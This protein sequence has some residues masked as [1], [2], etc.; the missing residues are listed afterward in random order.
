[1]AV[2]ML[3]NRAVATIRRLQKANWTAARAIADPTISLTLTRQGTGVIAAQD[4]VAIWAKAGSRGA[5]VSAPRSA[6]ETPSIDVTF[7]RVVE[8]GFDVEP[9]DTFTLDGQPGQ[10]VRVVR[11]KGIIAAEARLITGQVWP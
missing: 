4:V 9:S 7:R 8:D 11:D 1:M 6:D 2:P 3:T 10:I 5:H